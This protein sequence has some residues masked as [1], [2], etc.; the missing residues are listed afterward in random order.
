MFVVE[1]VEAIT[2]P[3]KGITA[4]FRLFGELWS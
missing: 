1:E 4:A 3:E 2:E